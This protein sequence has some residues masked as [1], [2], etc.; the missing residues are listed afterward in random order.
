MFDTTSFTDRGSSPRT[1]A[2]EL[3]DQSMDASAEQFC[4]AMLAGDQKDADQLMGELLELHRSLGKIY[5][6]V[7]GPALARVGDSW[8]RGD[9]GVDAEH[10]ATEIVISQM[11]R[12]RAQTT[13]RDF[14][15]P[16]RVLVSCVEGERHFIGARMVADLCLERAWNVD[17]LGADVPHG[18]L[19]DMIQRREPQVL[20]LS[21][22]MA[23]GF[24]KACELIDAVKRV[25]PSLRIVIGGQG[26]P[27][28]AS[29]KSFG[30]GC[31]ISRSAE[32][33]VETIARV[34]RT[35]RP[36][37]AL[38]EYQLVL[39]RRVRELRGQKGWTQEQLAEATR[40]TRVCIVAVEGG[41][42][43]VSMDILVRL[44][45]ALNVAPEVLLSDDR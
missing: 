3:V 38:K 1:K 40:V 35:V 24:I 45:N 11:E 16:Y 41:K 33:G 42:Q 30:S 31:E 29:L 23:D 14:R 17:F 27:S 21:M 32:D 26:V 22:T 13:R 19:I 5:T 7:I 37:A 44:A 39:S 28:D 43:N 8:C 25:A 6:R 34:L 10:L 36:G 15:S 2:E 12:L 4:Q 18:P 9:I 20:A